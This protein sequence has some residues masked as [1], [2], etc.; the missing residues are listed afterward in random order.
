M[1]SQ[2]TQSNALKKSK[3]KTKM[4][5]HQLPYQKIESVCNFFFIAADCFLSVIE[6]KVV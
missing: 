1:K 6:T 3:S 5:Q 4:L 2:P